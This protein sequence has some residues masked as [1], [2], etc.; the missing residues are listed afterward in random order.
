MSPIA[1]RVRT[2]RILA[3]LAIFSAVFASGA[4]V[5]GCQ[6]ATTAQPAGPPLST[7]I[8]SNSAAPPTYQVSV[9]DPTPIPRPATSVTT[10]SVPITS[11][12]AAPRLAPPASRPVPAPTIAAAAPARSAQESSS[13]DGDYYRNSDG[14]CVHRPQQA[15]APLPGATARCNDGTYSFSQ[16]RQGTCSGHRGVAQWL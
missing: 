8:G 15:A 12:Q 9:S 3:S 10:P 16:H 7:V 11:V 5:A 13:C 1:P 6:N 14:N 4:S 2:R